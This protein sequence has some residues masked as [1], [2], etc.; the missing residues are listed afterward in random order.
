MIETP[1]DEYPREESAATKDSI[2]RFEVDLEAERTRIARELHDTVGAD[3]A[4]SVALFKYY[5]EN[6]QAR[7]SREEVLRNILEMLGITL[8]NLRAL[9]QSLR[10]SDVGRIG[11]VSD[12]SDMAKAYRR[13]HDLD[14]LLEVNGSEEELT[15]RQRET[16]FQV[17]REALS[18]VRRHSECS[19][20]MIKCSFDEKPFLI[21]VTDWGV[22]F[23]GENPDGFG[24]IGMRER[25]AGIGG[26]LSLDSVP[27][28]GT[29]VLLYGPEPTDT[30]TQPAQQ[31]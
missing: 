7:G 13:F 17:V 5:F 29:R 20:C 28:R 12:L 30:L 31:T 24:L 18:N 14:V 4:A 8:K 19:T 27:A 16:V 1:D 2:R 10:S 21:E 11:L 15:H 22:G 23:I 26:R 25:A 3:L 9:L 6:P